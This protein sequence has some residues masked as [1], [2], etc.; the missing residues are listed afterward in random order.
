MRNVQA[1]WLRRSVSEITQ[2]IRHP[3]PKKVYR[4]IKKAFNDTPRNLR[5]AF[6]VR[7]GKAIV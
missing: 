7:A 2:K 6:D 3:F 4:N 1:K 5:H